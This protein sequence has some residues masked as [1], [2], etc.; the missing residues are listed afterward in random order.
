MFRCNLPPALLAE[1]PGSFKCYC[2]NTG[3]E[4]TPRK[5]QNTKLTPEREIFPPPLP[6]FELATFRS[7]VRRSNQQG[8]PAWKIRL[9]HGDTKSW[10]SENQEHTT[11]LFLTLPLLSILLSLLFLN[12][13]L[14]LTTTAATTSGSRWAT[15]SLY[16]CYCCLLYRHY[17]H[18][19]Y[20]STTSHCYYWLKITSVY[21]LLL[22]LLPFTTVTAAYYT[23]T[24]TTTTTIVLLATATTD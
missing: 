23:D 13:L 11:V 12:G 15:A 17:Y 3:V 7:R 10:A 2:G 9:R 20:Y 24:T 21:L 14:L 19:H 8:I 5:S 22:V 16:H 18:H 4:R 6:G 1:W